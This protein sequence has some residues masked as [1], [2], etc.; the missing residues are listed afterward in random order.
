MMVINESTQLGLGFRNDIYG[1]IAA[2]HVVNDRENDS[3]GATGGKA[4]NAPQDLLEVIKEETGIDPGLIHLTDG[5]V[6]RHKLCKVIF[7]NQMGTE[8]YLSDDTGKNYL[9]TETVEKCAEMV[10]IG[11]NFSASILRKLQNGWVNILIGRNEFARLVRIGEGVMG[12][13]WNNRIGEAFEFGFDLKDD[14]YYFA[15]SEKPMFERVVR[16]LTFI[17]L[18]D[19]ET[20]YL[21]AG[22]SNNKPKKDGKIINTSKF[23]VTIVDSK[24]NKILIRTEGFGVRGHYRLQPCGP[25]HSERKLVWIN[26]FEKH[27]YTRNAGALRE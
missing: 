11:E 2:L 18:G 22:R 7:G 8:L 17:L 15:H 5:D 9:I 26:A 16:I 1:L 6:L 19:I 23:G 24:W 21:E 10:R 20:V 13:Y 4:H 27:G 12:F 25:N 14:R 3:W